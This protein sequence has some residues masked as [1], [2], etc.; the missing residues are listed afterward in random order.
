MNIHKLIVLSQRSISLLLALSG[1]T[2][3]LLVDVLIEQALVEHVDNILLRVG[4]DVEAV[5]AGLEPLKVR[6]NLLRADVHRCLPWA[7]RCGSDWHRD[8]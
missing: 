6:T 7:A 5:L 2:S 3:K 8:Q 4:E 1:Q